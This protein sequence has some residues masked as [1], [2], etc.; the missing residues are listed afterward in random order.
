MGMSSGSGPGKIDTKFGF[1]IEAD[2]KQTG[3]NG[4]P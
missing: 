2:G 3:L 4:R 1:G